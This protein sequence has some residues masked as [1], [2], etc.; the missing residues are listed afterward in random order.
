MEYRFLGRSG[1]Q[2]SR[3][4]FGTMTFGGKGD[5][6][7]MGKASV[8]EARRQ[9]DICLDAGINI[10]DT[11]DMYSQGQSE[12]ILGKAIGPERRNQAIIATK[13]FFRMGS[14]IHD[15][16]LSRKH[17]IESCENSLRRLNTDYIDLYQVHQFDCYTPLEETLS[18]LNNLVEQGKVRYIGCSN[19]SGWHLMKAL[20]IS[21]RKLQERFISQQVYYSLIARELELELLP[22]SLDQGVGIMVWS[23]LSFGLLSGKYRRN[24]PIPDNSRLSNVEAPGT[25]NWQLLYNVVDVLEEVA[26]AR[27]KTIPQVALNWLLQRPG[28]SSVIIGART[29]QQLKDNLGAVGWSLT[30]EE[31]ERLE[32]I[33]AVPE[34]Y[35]YWHQHLWG[36]ERNP[37]FGR[38]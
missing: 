31:V 28:V 4:C 38:V 24:Q 14:G 21:E 1:L 34:N 7:H 10:F 37:K 23:P 33:S 2:V 9:V 36:A 20:G 17:I 22:L 27:G 6:Q 11:A 3:L 19:Y 35:P 26:K 5:F 25:I 15:T 13:V 8:D 30:P 12:E 32:K 29:E 16:G 18:A